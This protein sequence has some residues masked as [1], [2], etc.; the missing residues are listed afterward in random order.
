MT[1]PLETALAAHHAGLCVLPPKEDGSK[2]PDMVSWTVYQRRQST[3][4]EIRGWYGNGRKRNGLGIVCGKVSRQLEMLEFEGRAVEDGTWEAY[5]AACRQAGLQGLLARIQRGYGERSP[6][7]G[8]HLLYY[9]LAGARGNT[10]LAR[11][12]SAPDELATDPKEKIQKLIETRGEGGYVIVA[13]TSDHVHLSS[14][15][16][17][18][19]AGSFETIAEISGEER[20]ALFAIARSFDQTPVEEWSQPKGRND[21]R[22]LPPGEDF[23]ERGDWARDILVPAGWSYTGSHGG[24]QHWYRRGAGRPGWTSATITP[25]GQFLYVFST[26]TDLPVEKGLSKWRAYA[27]LHHS[28][29]FSAAAADLRDKG[30]GSQ[31]KAG[32]VIHGRPI[33]RGTGLPPPTFY[34]AD[35]LERMEI[36]SPKMIVPGIVLVGLNMLAGKAKLGKSWLALDL[37]LGVASGQQVLN[38]MA[39]EPGDVLYLALEDNQSRM[40]NRLDQ[41]ERGWPNRLHIGHQLPKLNEGGLQVIENWLEANPEAKLVVIDIWKRVRQSR[42]KNASI[43]DEDYEHLSV[44]QSLAM[45]FEVAILVVHHT[46]KAAEADVFDEVSGS[47]GIMAALD[48]C[49]ILH[50][51][52][53]EADGELWITGRDVEE[54]KLALKLED[55]RWSLLGRA[56]E[57]ARSRERRLILE[58]MEEVIAQTVETAET[59]T[60]LSAA[61]VAKITGQSRNTTKQLFW[62]MLT[63]GELERLPNSLY[64]PRITANQSNSGNRGNRGSEGGYRLSQHITPAREGLAIPR[65]REARQPC[66]ACGKWAYVAGPEGLP[67]RRCNACQRV[68]T[69]G[70]K[71]P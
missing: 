9:C 3:E 27:F 41:L 45:R 19:L 7:G 31:D 18:L 52:R 55:G 47:G 44:L 60:G 61:E 65:A 37:A 23:N 14:K 71:E 54:S 58:A 51:S 25:D 15:P 53:S 46:K 1:I 22:D 16:W 43:Y 11:R 34:R 68:W 40:H 69:P 56:G 10:I 2:A 13:P 32:V 62:K 17:Q 5:K 4:D 63:S 36:P 28:G 42:Q 49:L 50:R 66:P 64:R 29:D 26:A 30:Y 48:T 39:V 38:A 57:V 21:T 12:P 59:V 24:R 67:Q 20:D 35:A 33:A 6:A 70:Q 8:Y